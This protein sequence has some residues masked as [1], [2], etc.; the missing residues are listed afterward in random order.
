M[1]QQPFSC[2]L[3]VF[4]NCSHEES[5]CHCGDFVCAVYETMARK[6]GDLVNWD[7]LFDIKKT[8]CLAL[9][10]SGLAEHYFQ[11]SDGVKSPYQT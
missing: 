11:A 7:G 3:T 1:S 6:G 5:R 4:C 9:K 2:V 10:F 8:L